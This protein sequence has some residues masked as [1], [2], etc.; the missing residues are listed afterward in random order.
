MLKRIIRTNESGTVISI[1]A[2]QQEGL[3]FDPGACRVILCGV[4]LTVLSVSVFISTKNLYKYGCFSIDID[5][6]IV[7][8]FMLITQNF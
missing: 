5:T 4:S 3:M 2:S 7:F 1:L 8:F 6:G